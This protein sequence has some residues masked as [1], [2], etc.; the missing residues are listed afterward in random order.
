M[1]RRGALGLV[2]GLVLVALLIAGTVTALVVSGR[3]GTL[4]R[5]PKKIAGRIV[6]VGAFSVSGPL[7]LKVRNI[8]GNVSVVP[9]SADRVLVR[10]NL[11]IKAQLQ[12]GVLVVYCPLKHRYLGGGTVCDDYTN[13]TVIIEVPKTPKMVA[14]ENVVGTVMGLVWTDYTISNVVGNVYLNAKGQVQVDNVVG[15]VIVS[16]PEGKGARVSVKN[17]L[18]TVINDASGNGS[19]VVSVDNVV[20]NVEVGG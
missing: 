13:G 2:L 10:S 3:I 8:N 16:V 12:N 20:G 17:V 7:E 9:G 6:D 4:H 11:P 14:V 5:E 19:V 18:G 15:N 1:K